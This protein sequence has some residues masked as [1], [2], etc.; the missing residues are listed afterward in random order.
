[1][2]QVWLLDKQGGG[3]DWYFFDSNFEF[4]HGSGS[5]L[6]VLD[7]DKVPDALPTTST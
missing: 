5:V 2:S 7:T 3:G 6:K 4:D 1:M